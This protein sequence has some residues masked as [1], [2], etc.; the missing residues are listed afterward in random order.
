[1]RLPIVMLSA[2]HDATA[3][4]VLMVLPIELWLAS[5]MIGFARSAAL[6]NAG[7]LSGEDTQWATLDLSMSTNRVVRSGSALTEEV[8]W[9]IVSS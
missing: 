9:P 7:A 4:A 8:A 5:P 6:D 2:I 1:M 3:A